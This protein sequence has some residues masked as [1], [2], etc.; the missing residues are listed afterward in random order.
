ME[1][2][3]VICFSTAGIFL[4]FLHQFLSFYQTIDSFLSLL[5]RISRAAATCRYYVVHCVG[6]YV[7]RVSVLVQYYFL[8][9]VRVLFC[10]APQSVKC[11]C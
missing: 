11:W 4:R 5:S 2:V 8:V 3:D 10:I 9:R 6:T 7:G 1:K